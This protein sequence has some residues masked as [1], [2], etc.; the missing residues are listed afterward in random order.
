MARSKKPIPLPMRHHHRPQFTNGDSS[1]GEERL[2]ALFILGCVLFSPLCLHVF[3]GSAPVF[4]WLP[5]LFLYLFVAW[6]ALIAAIA[7]VIETTRSRPP[8]EDEN[9]GRPRIERRRP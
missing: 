1:R 9:G 3:R 5:P 8:D 2:V 7:V 6:A 4:G